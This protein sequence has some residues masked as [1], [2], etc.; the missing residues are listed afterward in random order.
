MSSCDSHMMSHD[1]QHGVVGLCKAIEAVDVI[2][3]RVVLVSR[4]TER[5]E[6]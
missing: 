5:L 2:V 1:S 6:H 4:K 3:S